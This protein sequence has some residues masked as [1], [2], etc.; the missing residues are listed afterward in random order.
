ME[1]ST[2]NMIFGIF[3]IVII[4]IASFAGAVLKMGLRHPLQM[5]DAPKERFGEPMMRMED[6]NE[7]Y[8]SYILPYFSH[9]NNEHSVQFTPTVTDVACVTMS[10]GIADLLDCQGALID[11]VSVKDDRVVNLPGQETCNSVLVSK[12]PRNPTD[13]DIKLL[14]GMYRLTKACLDIPVD[15]VDG[16]GDDVTIDINS[17]DPS[18]TFIALNRPI[19]LAT[20]SSHLYQFDYERDTDVRTYRGLNAEATRERDAGP[21]VVSFSLKRV[22]DPS[23]LGEGSAKRNLEDIYS[24]NSDESPLHATLFY[25]RYVG[26]MEIGTIRLRFDEQKAVTLVFPLSN[27]IIDGDRTWFNSHNYATPQFMIRR[28]I[29]QSEP[30]GDGEYL[31]RIRSAGSTLARIGVRNRGY[32]VVTYTTNTLIMCYMSRDRVQVVRKNDVSEITVTDP[33]L[34]QIGVDSFG[35]RV[36]A[37]A[38]PANTYSIANLYDLYTR[39]VAFS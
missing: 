27:R 21:S 33:V 35:A 37:I 31:V 39:L 18:A 19:F 1:P 38:H 20:D 36:P 3:L 2:K 22:N 7:K 23:I 32:L 11:T 14:N 6:K 8:E 28:S 24:D 13:A 12:Q 30:D 10:D 26:P 4:I 5:A 29:T 17:T 15:D 25:L 16:N 34:F 9:D